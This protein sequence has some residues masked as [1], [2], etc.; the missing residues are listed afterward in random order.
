MKKAVIWDL[1]GTLFDSYG[2]IVESLYLALKENGVELPL[3]EIHSHAIHFSIQSLLVKVEETYGASAAQVQQRYSQI[4]VGKYLDIKAMNH[5]IEVLV[6]LEE[7]GITN[8]VFTHRGKTTIPVLENLNMAG[9]FQDIITSQSGFKRKPD[10]EGIT[11]FINK[12]DLNPAQTY[13]VGDRA[14]DMDC[15]KNAGIAGILF[16]SEGSMDVSGG[17]ENY[18]VHDLLEVL[19]I[20]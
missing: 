19:E 15:A 12:Y 13:Y 16:L 10:P 14:L 8:Y 3:Q 5:A 7:R 6:A 2:V 9:F 17:S 4:S 18:I 1:D 20:I 11:Y